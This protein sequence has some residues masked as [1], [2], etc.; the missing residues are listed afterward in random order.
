VKAN[1]SEAEKRQA[2]IVQKK[3]NIL[4]K[5]LYRLDE[6]RGDMVKNLH[7][8]SA[9]E[10]KTILIVHGPKLKRQE[11][12][13]A[14]ADIVARQADDKDVV[15]ISQL[16]CL[17]KDFLL[18]ERY[19]PAFSKIQ[20]ATEPAIQK[21]CAMADDVRHP[22]SFRRSCVRSLGQIASPL[23][24]PTLVKL[25]DQDSVASNVEDAVLKIIGAQGPRLCWR[26]P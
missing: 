12:R 26:L 6:M 1:P 11:S 7:M 8:M 2:D 22:R 20:T 16:F 19:V 23:A 3:M 10:A 9:D 17:E 15:A 5:Q 13:L 24:L 25:M 14:F 18:I 21:L 4:E